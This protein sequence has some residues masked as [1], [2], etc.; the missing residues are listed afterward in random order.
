MDPGKKSGEAGE[1]DQ[2]G[3]SKNEFFER[4]V[5]NLRKIIEKPAKYHAK[6]CEMP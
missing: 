4:G 1:G 2:P 5:L 3:E 6:S